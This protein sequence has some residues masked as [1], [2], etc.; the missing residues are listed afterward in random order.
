MLTNMYTHC[1]VLLGLFDSIHDCKDK[2]YGAGL[3]PGF[4]FEVEAKYVSCLE[5]ALFYIPI[6]PGNS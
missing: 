3:N 2:I 1:F 6:N 4:K 5:D